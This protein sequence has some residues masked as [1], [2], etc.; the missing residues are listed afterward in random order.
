VSLSRG[1][2][3]LR[4]IK[5]R[6]KIAAWIAA[7]AALSTTYYWPSLRWPLV[8]RGDGGLGATGHLEPGDTLPIIRDAIIDSALGWRGMK[9]WFIERMGRGPYGLDSHDSLTRADTL[10]IVRRATQDDQLGER[11]HR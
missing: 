9:R 2:A 1:Y 10:R 6:W 4:G 7:V 3:R 5:R 8:Y 11:R